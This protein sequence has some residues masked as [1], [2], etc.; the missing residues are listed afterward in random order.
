[1]LILASQSPRRRELIRMI[2]P[3]F[4]VRPFEFD[5]RQ[6][7]EDDPERLVQLLAAGKAASVLAGAEDI[8]VGC[9]TV[10]V[11]DGVIFGKPV[12]SADAKRM[13]RAL[14]G[15]EHTVISGVCVLHQGKSECFACKTKVRFY[16]LTKDEITRYVASGEPM[17][18]AGSYG[19]QGR[20]AL[21]VQAID[22]DYFNV[23]GLPVAELARVL[24]RLNEFV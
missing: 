14:S 7:T 23:V 10:V 21:L 3:D 22:G 12:D 9:D 5:E 17:D 24:R 15:R 16:P 18:K 1:M 20:G 6:V 13:L 2:T 11:L 8:V 19:I 4:I